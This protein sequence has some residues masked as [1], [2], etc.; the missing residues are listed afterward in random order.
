MTCPI[1][2]GKIAEDPDRQKMYNEQ[3]N[4]NDMSCRNVTSEFR[5]RH[6]FIPL[7]C[8]QVLRGRVLLSQVLRGR[9]SL[10]RT[11]TSDNL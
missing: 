11:N 6:F 10:L 4:N 2:R 5:F 7:H 1:L 8:P 9:G 3:R